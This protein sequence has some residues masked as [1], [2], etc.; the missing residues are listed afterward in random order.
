MHNP[1]TWFEI[2]AVE[3]DRAVSFY[4]AILNQDLHKSEFMGD[5]HGFFPVDA[6]GVGGA[7]IKREGLTPSATGIVIYLNAGNDLNG[8][9]ARVASAGGQVLT[10]VIPIDP[11]GHMA[12][13]LDT[14]GNHIGLHQPPQA[15]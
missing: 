5:P 8:I 9:V 12:I 2:P 15:Q 10:P 4:S 13:I 11:Q 7:I 1:I 3:F 6:G 14:E